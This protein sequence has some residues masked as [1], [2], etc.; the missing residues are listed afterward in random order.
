[1]DAARRVGIHGIQ[2]T[3]DYGAALEELRGLLG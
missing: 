2:V 1:V 3:E